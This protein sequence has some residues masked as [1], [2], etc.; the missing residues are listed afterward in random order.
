MTKTGLGNVSID[1]FFQRHWQKR[2]LLV[3]D[4]LPQ[5]AGLVRLNTLLDLASRDDLESRLVQFEKKNWHVRYGPFTRRELARLPASGWTLLVQ[6]VD[7]VLPAARDLL[8]RFRFVP[9][10]RL[11]D[12]MVSYAPPGGGV[13]PHFD[14][15]DVFLLQL[16]G[17][18][19]WRVSAQRDLSLVEGAPLRILRRFR[20]AREWVV[21]AGDLLY[22]PPR[23]AHDGV[24]VTNCITCSI[25]FRA[26][27]AQELGVKFL[28][29]LQE[30]LNLSGM[31]ADPDLRSQR[32]PAE[33]GNAMV[34]K[35]RRL[36]DRL[37]W[38]EADVERFFGC[39]LSE[40]KANVVFSRPLR[41]LAAP[42]FLRRAARHGVRLALPT[43][44]LFRKGT[45]FINGEACPAPPAAARTLRRLADEGRLLPGEIDDR[46]SK[47]WLYQWYRAGY[48]QLADRRK[49]R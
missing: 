39:Y 1:Q 10:A 29:F 16:Q 28:E 20:A 4:A 38:S 8:D 21:R 47:P 26:P 17:A 44:M 12:V 35:L 15:Y 2:P 32:H 45:F 7:R 14:S 11:D 13:G 40:P 24:A 19:R 31:Y 36:L 9:L 43:R 48:L 5:C 25:G 41:P 6:G 33:L 18:R 49:R 3:R 27:G 30:R 23:Y 46:V 37:D 34:R 22:L 42:D